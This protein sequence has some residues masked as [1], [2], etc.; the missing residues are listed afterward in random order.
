MVL[1]DKFVIY[2]MICIYLLSSFLIYYYRKKANKPNNNLENPYDL[3]RNKSIYDL[4]AFI[5][6]MNI[7]IKDIQK[8]LN[9]IQI[10][11]EVKSL[12]MEKILLD[13]KD[14]IDGTDKFLEENLNK[15]NLKIKAVK[16]GVDDE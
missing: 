13:I 6:T 8:D 15:Y 7:L 9:N 16:R 1:I 14:L 3:E 4:I 2:L 12:L 11:D 10:E 5:Y